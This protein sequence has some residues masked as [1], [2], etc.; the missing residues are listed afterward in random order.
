MN[1]KLADSS[2]AVT[3]EKIDNIVLQT[4]PSTLTHITETLEKALQESRPH[5]IRKIERK[6]KKITLSDV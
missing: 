4:D 1:L 5:N 2:L 3:A 6:I